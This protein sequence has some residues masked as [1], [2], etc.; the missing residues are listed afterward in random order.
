MVS[1]TRRLMAMTL[2]V[3]LAAGMQVFGHEGID[4]L[5]REVKSMDF[6]AHRLEGFLIWVS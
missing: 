2:R 4:F 6:L 1:V 5:L 3:G